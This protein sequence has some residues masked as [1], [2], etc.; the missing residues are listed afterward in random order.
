MKRWIAQGVALLAVLALVGCGSTVEAPATASA[1]KPAATKSAAPKPLRFAPTSVG[2]AACAKEGSGAGIWVNPT[3][4]CQF[5]KAVVK[6]YAASPPKPKAM[7]VSAWSPVTR[8][9]YSMACGSVSSDRIGCSGGHGA[10]LQFLVAEGTRAA[11]ESQPHAIAI[12]PPAYPTFESIASHEC[13]ANGEVLREGRGY[14]KSRLR[15]EEGPKCEPKWERECTAMG[16]EVTGQAGHLECV[17]IKQ[18]TA[19][20]TSEGAKERAE[21]CDDQEENPAVNCKTENEE[22]GGKDR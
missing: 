11:R 16:N 5:A 8:K 15:W 2:S 9:S 20:E 1:S 19:T 12:K 10:Y 22:A 13:E 17:P 21:Q 7:T 18:E 4:S 14:G 6:A 3:T